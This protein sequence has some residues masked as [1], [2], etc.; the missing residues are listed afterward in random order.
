VFT[1]LLSFLVKSKGIKLG[2]GAV[3]GSGLVA[4]VLGLHNDVTSKIEKQEQDQ[5]EYVEL[6]L[7]P[8]QVQIQG[9]QKDQSETKTMVRDI[10]TYLLNKRNK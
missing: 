7:K 4:L 9:L 8:V 1:A 2:A 6:I 5:K 3:T 10:H